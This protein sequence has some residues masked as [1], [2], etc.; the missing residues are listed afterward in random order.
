MEKVN[1]VYHTHAYVRRAPTRSIQPI[2]LQ[3]SIFRL[4]LISGKKR[5]KDVTQWMGVK[6]TRYANWRRRG[7]VPYQIIIHALLI[8]GISLDWFFAAG[9]RLYY[10]RPDEFEELGEQPRIGDRERRMRL[11]GALQVIDPVLEELGAER[12]E[13]H[14]D[15]M[16]EVFFSANNDWVSLSVALRAVAQALA[17]E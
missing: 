3:Q 14:R 2:N 9:E 1:T 16:L 11:L 7:T 13:K 5:I 10:P 12:N 15:L 17:L 6:E 8:H 4:K